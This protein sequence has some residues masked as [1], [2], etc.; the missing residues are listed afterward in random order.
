MMKKFNKI[1]SKENEKKLSIVR[2]PE[3][4][5]NARPLYSIQQRDIPMI[6]QQFKEQHRLLLNTYKSNTMY[7]CTIDE[8]ETNISAFVRDG[9]VSSPSGPA[10]RS[11]DNRTE[12][13]IVTERGIEPRTYRYPGGC[14]T[15]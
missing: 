4:Q 12:Q 3:Y 2:I 1:Q 7:S 10:A 11:Y 15:N 8:W 6:R 9:K 14:S 5:L 13:K